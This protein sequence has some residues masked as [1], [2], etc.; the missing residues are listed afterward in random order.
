M[1]KAD[2]N[3]HRQFQH[4]NEQCDD[5]INDEMVQKSGPAVNC[6]VRYRT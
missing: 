5:E 6:Y 4:G 3:K 2:N 1:A